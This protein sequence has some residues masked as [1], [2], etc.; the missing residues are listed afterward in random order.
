MDNGQRRHPTFSIFV[1]EEQA[2]VLYNAIVQHDQEVSQLNATPKYKVALATLR[3]KIVN[4]RDAIK[5]RAK[6]EI[7]A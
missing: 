3:Q 6:K 1:T 4:M 2:E 7:R 5:R